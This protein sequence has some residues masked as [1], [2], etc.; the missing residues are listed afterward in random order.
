M[1]F[2][3]D[4]GKAAAE[5]FKVELDRLEAQNPELIARL[6]MVWKECY[7]ESGHKVLGRI[8]LGQ[9]VDAATSKW[10]NMRRG[11]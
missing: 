3:V 7:S 10:G 8:L 1:G 4:K 6:R 2:D 9:S 5:Q 11:D